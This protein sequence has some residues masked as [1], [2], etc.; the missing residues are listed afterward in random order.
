MLDDPGQEVSFSSFEL[1]WS[2]K[3]QPIVVIQEVSLSAH[4]QSYS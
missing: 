3:Y 4:F 1:G 2:S